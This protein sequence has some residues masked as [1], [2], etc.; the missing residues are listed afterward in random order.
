P[1]V[2]H[3]GRQDGQDARRVA[4]HRRYR[5]P[6]PDVGRSRVRLPV[7]QPG[8][9]D[10]D[11]QHGDARNHHSQRRGQPGET[12]QQRQ[13][14]GDRTGGCDI[15][16]GGNPVPA[17]TDGVRQQRWPF[18]PAILRVRIPSSV[19]FGTRTL[20]PAPGVLSRTQGDGQQRFHCPMPSRM[21]PTIAELIPTHCRGDG[22]SPNKIRLPAIT[23]SGKLAETAE[24]IETRPSWLPRT[25]AA[26]PALSAIPEAHAIST[27]RPPGRGPKAPR[28]PRKIATATAPTNSASRAPYSGKNQPVCWAARPSR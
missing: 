28:A 9:A 26:T 22:R 4:E 23:T 7:V 8:I 15:R 13:R 2:G 12:D 10:G 14:E 1:D 17:E 20:C 11:Q 6:N 27:E 5:F 24:V 3:G 16:D 25:K 19:Y 18:L 21:R